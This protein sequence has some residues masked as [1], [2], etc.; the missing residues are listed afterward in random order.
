MNVDSC[1]TK[2]GD[3][4]RI[5][6]TIYSSILSRFRN[7]RFPTSIILKA[8]DDRNKKVLEAMSRELGQPMIRKLNASARKKRGE[9]EAAEAES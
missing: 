4:L 9:N 3:V 5:T 7:K 1:P 6:V 2:R 8:T